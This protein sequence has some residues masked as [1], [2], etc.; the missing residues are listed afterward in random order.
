[1]SMFTQQAQDFLAQSRLAVV[2]VSRSNTST[3]NGIFRTLKQ[4]GYIVYPVNAS[5]DQVEGEPCYRSV[6]GLPEPVDGVVIVTRAAHTLEVVQDCIA[7]GIPRVWMHQNGFAP[8]EQSSVSEEAVALCREKGVEVIAGGCPMLFLEGFHKC[9]R[10]VMG[11]TGK[12][13]T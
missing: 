10:V 1:M 5:A 4:K 8:Q 6:R 2:G 7:A 3:A 11:W 12:L 13:P 9:M